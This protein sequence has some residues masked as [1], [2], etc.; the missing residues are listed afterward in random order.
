MGDTSTLEEFVGEDTKRVDG[1]ERYRLQK[2]GSALLLPAGIYGHEEC[3]P[4]PG[5]Q[6]RCWEKKRRGRPIGSMT[7]QR[8]VAVK[9]QPGLVE[10]VEVRDRDRRDGEIG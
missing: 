9:T 3:V 2:N 6:K 10:H 7:K 5:S 1:R 8:T 4:S